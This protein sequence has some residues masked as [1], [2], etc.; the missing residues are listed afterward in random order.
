M[1]QRVYPLRMLGMGLGGLLAGCVL[2]ERQASWAAFAFPAFVAFVWPQ[3]AYFLARRSADPHKAEVRNLLIDSALAAALVPLMHFSLLPSVVLLTL[4]V[5]DKITTGLR[6]LW[7]RSL[8]GMA[9]GMAIS[10]ALTG[11]YWAPDTSLWVTIAT[12]P[13]M[14][15]HSLAV[16]MV[17][18]RYIRMAARHNQL[19]DEQRRRDALTGLYERGYWQEQA[20]A[21]WHA[22]QTLG[23]PA[24]L[25]MVDIDHF[26]PINDEYGHTVG[27]EVLRA[28]AQVVRSSVRGSDCPGRFGGDEFAILLRDMQP[29]DALLIAQRI[30]RQAEQLRVRN[31]PALRVTTSI[32]VAA[33]DR[34]HRNLRSWIDAADV[35]LYRAKKS[36]RNRVAQVGDGDGDG[37]G[38]NGSQWA[39][40][41]S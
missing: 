21:A 2:W 29:Q 19:L 20:E 31:L 18:Y 9:I 5:A 36:G 35:A 4:T 10:A 34:S 30:S 32:G 6:G 28:V 23:Q 3:L 17:S 13:V 33:V 25:L 37:G 40:V 7:L 27:D 26:K 41:A 39:P 12:L 38:Y 11:V 8:P 15:L 24:C 16:S 22:H 14:T 1:Y